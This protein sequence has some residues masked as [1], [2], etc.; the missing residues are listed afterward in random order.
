M[1]QEDV[2]STDCSDSLKPYSYFL[3]HLMR[4]YVSK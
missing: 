2:Y 4:V 3:V 1:G